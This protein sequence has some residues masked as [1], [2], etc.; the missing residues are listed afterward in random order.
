MA[1]RHHSEESRDMGH[2]MKSE[3]RGHSS[4]HHSM[5]PKRGSF[6]GDDRS[7]PCNLP[8]SVMDK[9]LPY[10]TGFGGRIKS[11]LYDGVESQ[12]STDESDL[13]R[14]GKPGKY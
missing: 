2:D 11:D 6:I 10:T 7:Q 9:A 4:K 12:M 8:S 1:K 5:S 3:M 13:R 14:H